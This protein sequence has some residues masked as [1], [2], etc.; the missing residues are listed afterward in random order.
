VKTTPRSGEVFW[1]EVHE[2]GAGLHAVTISPLAAVWRFD[3][4]P[5]AAPR[6]VQMR[7]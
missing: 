1:D 2:H 6:R 5:G 4:A 3:S 7:L